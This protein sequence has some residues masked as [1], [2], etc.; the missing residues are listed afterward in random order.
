MFYIFLIINNIYPLPN[1]IVYYKVEGTLYI[2]YEK[3]I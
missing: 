1:N 3:N 2:Y